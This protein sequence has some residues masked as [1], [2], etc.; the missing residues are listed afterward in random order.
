LT[1]GIT[2]PRFEDTMATTH[3]SDGRHDFSATERP[4]PLAPRHR[5]RRH[6]AMAAAAFAGGSAAVFAVLA[7]CVLAAVIVYYQYH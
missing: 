3:R 6:E 4:A 2:G 5:R 7:I 1:Q